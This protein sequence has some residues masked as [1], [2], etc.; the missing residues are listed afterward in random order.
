LIMRTAALLLAA[1]LLVPGCRQLLD[2]PSDLSSPDAGADDSGDQGAEDGADDGSS[3]GEDGADA[4]GGEPDAGPAPDGGTDVDASAPCGGQNLFIGFDDPAELD[5]WLLDFRQECTMTIEGGQLRV[6]QPDPPGFCRMFRE[7]SM[8]IIDY[9][10]QINV[11]DPG[12]QNVSLVF[13]VILSDGTDDIR[14]RRRVR[15]ERDNG[16]IKAGECTGEVC[17]TEVHG[18]MPYDPARHSWWRFDHDS[19]TGT[20]EFEFAGDD[21]MFARPPELTPVSGITLQQVTCVGVELGTYEPSDPGTAA[22]DFLAGGSG[23]E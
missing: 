2:I 15:I 20:I 7:L 14:D 6:N 21:E 12:D 1:L 4:G 9:G 23:V 11:V 17:D 5:S 3:D 22:F 10:F 13:S 19:D 16:Q 8:D 18:V